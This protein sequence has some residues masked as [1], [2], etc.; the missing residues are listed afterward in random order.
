MRLRLRLAL[1]CRLGR[2]DFLSTDGNRV[3]GA[4]TDIQYR[5]ARN[6]GTERPLPILIMII[7]QL[8]SIAVLGATHHCLPAWISSIQARV[9][10]FVQPIDERTLGETRDNSYGMVREALQCLRITPRSRFPRRPQAD[11]F[12]L[13]H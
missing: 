6:H 8:A 10:C 5:V 13:L 4:L 7:K 11:G 1:A 2:G 9:G 3:E 12:T